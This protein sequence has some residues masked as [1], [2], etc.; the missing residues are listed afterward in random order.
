MPS[1]GKRTP[2]TEVHFEGFI[3]AYEAENRSKVEDERW[4]VFE[5]E[6]IAQKDDSLDIGLIVDE[7]LV[8]YENLPNPIESAEDAIAKLEQAVALLN[9]VVEELEA[10]EVN[11][12]FV[13]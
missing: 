10:V 4:N 12:V 9:E 5:R 3:K 11:E 8:A 13:K 1:F 2:L 7:S 6:E